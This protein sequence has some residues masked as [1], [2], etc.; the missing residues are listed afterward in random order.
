MVCHHPT[1]SAGLRHCCS[2]DIIFLVVE[3]QDSTCS[4][5][6]LTLLLSLKYMAY[7][8]NINPILVTPFLG[9]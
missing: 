8:I 2:V 1:K 3:G 6:N 5:L 9:N 7:Y 4:R